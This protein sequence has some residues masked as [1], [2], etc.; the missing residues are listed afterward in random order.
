MMNKELI[1][2]SDEYNEKIGVL[3]TLFKLDFDPYSVKVVMDQDEPYLLV[4]EEKNGEW[5][6]FD[7]DCRSD[8]EA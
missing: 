7:P 4:K 1:N 6:E 3:R 5:L 8:E 2:G